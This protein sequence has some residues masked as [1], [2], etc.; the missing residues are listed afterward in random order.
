[1]YNL[2]WGGTMNYSQY[3]NYMFFYIPSN[4]AQ[5]HL[6]VSDVMGYMAEE[7]FFYNRKTF[8]NNL[9]LLVLKGTLY[10]EQYNTKYILKS[11]QGILMKLTDQ[12]KYYTDPVDTAH[13]VWFH[14][15]GNPVFPILNTLFHYDYLP[16][17]FQDDC[18]IKNSIYHCFEITQKHSEYFEYELSAHIYQI[19][20]H[21]TTPYLNKIDHSDS[22]ENSWFTEQIY[23]YIRDHIYE[24][25]TLDQLSAALHMNKFNF[26]RKFNQVFDTSP[27]QFV[28]SKKIQYALK[29][30][31]EPNLSINSIA[32]ALAF[33]DLGHFSRTFKKLL[34]ISPSSYRKYCEQ[35]HLMNPNSK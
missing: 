6:I 9:V 31:D 28:I 10:V 4:F 7:D 3:T 26:C 17:I 5:Q 30:L 16:I 18:F 23:L 32:H 35:Y 19:I 34:G 22:T 12:H 8:N 20:L 2:D 11:G 21:I 27:M 1:M 29:L 33:S 13:I 15:R 14:F 25:I 24:K